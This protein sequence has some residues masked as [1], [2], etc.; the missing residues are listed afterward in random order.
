[1]RR[2]VLRLAEKLKPR[3]RSASAGIHAAGRFL[4]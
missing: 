2:Y 4:P 3:G 1:M